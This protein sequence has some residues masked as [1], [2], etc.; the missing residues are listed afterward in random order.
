MSKRGEVINWSK[1]PNASPKPKRLHL[2]ED[3]EDGLFHCPVLEC[4]H[5]GFATQRGCRKHVKKKH[6]WFYYFDEKPDI[7][8]ADDSKK[9]S[10]KQEVVENSARST[11]TF[12]SFDISSDIAQQIYS[13]LTGTGGGCKSGRQAKQIVSRCLKFMKF[14]CEDEEELTF[15]IVDF[16]LCS[17]N[18]LFKFIDMLQ[19]EW[20]LGH[21]GRIGYVDAV[22]EMVDFR[23]VNGASQS[24]V[25]SLSTTEIYLKRVRRTVSKMM[26]IQW[27][28][29]Q[30]IEALEA[31]GHWAT[32]EQL[33]EAVARYLPRYESV[34][35]TCKERPRA[36]SPL[37][38]SFATKFLALYLFIKVKGSRPMTYQYL[39]VDMVQKSKANG[40]F[41]DQKMFKTVAKYGFD[42]IYLTDTNMQVLDGYISHIRPQLK[43]SCDFVLVTRNGGQ[44]SKLGE[45]MSKLVFDA[46]GKHVHPTRYRQIVETESS[47][48]LS[49]N[50]Q[51]TISED[52]K[53][54][55][56]VARLHYQKQRSREV[57]TK[58]H[59]ILKELQGDK[60]SELENDVRARLSDKSSSSQDQ[61]EKTD[62]SSSDEVETVKEV[63][64]PERPAAT[65]KVKREDALKR[66]GPSAGRKKS[67]PFSPEED[68]QL[69]AG[70]KRYGFGQWKAILRDP[71]F[72]FEKCRTANSLLCRASRRFPSYSKG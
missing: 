45:S 43:P 65:P 12:P 47:K 3:E 57:A 11:K 54:T 26:R 68:K 9:F 72:H 69:K 32:L 17:P 64:P 28:D 36:A 53:H 56:A 8:H 39:T 42:S 38:L 61:D 5:D 66:K 20:K 71:D 23:K 2:E 14:C 63:P 41:I 6:L 19:D 16:S 40:G 59:S 46:T 50:A 58:A 62:S 25:S 10:V 15:D 4:K 18:L 31:K 51:S 44:H 55:S 24:V 21:A 7:K 67:L 30:D 52:Q 37:D 35:K 34:L 29:E 60:G 22:A 27:N 49:S 13:W 48:N 33:L 1:L 70:L